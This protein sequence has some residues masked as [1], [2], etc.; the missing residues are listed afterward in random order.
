MFAQPSS[1]VRRALVGAGLFGLAALVT[2]AAPAAAQ[3]VSPERALLN[4]VPLPYAV[5]V[6]PQSSVPQVDGGWAL[7]AHTAPGRPAVPGVATRWVEET[8]AITAE[9]ALLGAVTQ[10]PRRRLTLAW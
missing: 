2:L 6:Q 4:V 10:S 3:G 7:L 8:P 5:V 1:P 9:R